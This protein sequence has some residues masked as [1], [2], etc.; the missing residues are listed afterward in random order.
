MPQSVNHDEEKRKDLCDRMIGGMKMEDGRWMDFEG[1]EV[2]KWAVPVDS[3][4][5]LPSTA[6]VTGP[7]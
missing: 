7:R 4:V 1:Y 6:A 5:D 3:R 2:G